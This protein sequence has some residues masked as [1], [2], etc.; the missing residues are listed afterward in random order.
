VI[1]SGHKVEDFAGIEINKDKEG[2]V[3]YGLKY[4]QL[5]APITKAVQEL[6]ARVEELEAT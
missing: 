6:T 5:I 1:E 2:E 3:W 4:E